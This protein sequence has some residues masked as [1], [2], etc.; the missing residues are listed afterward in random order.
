MSVKHWRCGEYANQSERHAAEYLTARLQSTVTTGDWIL[1]TNYA[2]SSGS[3]YLADELDLVVV[4]S[5]GV[6][7]IEIKHWRAQTLKAKSSLSPNMKR[8]NSTKKQRA[9][10][11]KSPKRALSISVSLKVS[12][13]SR[14]TR[15]KSM[16]REIS[17][18]GSTVSSCSVCRSGKTSL[19]LIVHRF[20]QKSK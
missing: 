6:T 19:G 7:A 16:L 12:F 3:Q 15:M 18:S 5:L 1:M 11:A 17:V 10:R 20:S 8:T 4:S 9:S 2:S 13:Y 14:R